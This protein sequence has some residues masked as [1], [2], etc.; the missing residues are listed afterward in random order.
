MF[1]V[2]HICVIAGLIMAAAL[3]YKIKFDS[4]LQGEKVAKVEGKIRTTRS[5]IAVLRAEWT[6]LDTPLRIQGLTGRH[7]HLQPVKPSQFSDFDH[8]P[9]RPLPIVPPAN[10]DALGAM[11][12]NPDTTGSVPA[13]PR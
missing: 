4:T 13:A 11:L 1:R 3:V 8:L 2:I 5:I 6:R 7:L 9:D 10:A 12:S